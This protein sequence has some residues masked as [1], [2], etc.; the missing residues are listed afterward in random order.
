MHYRPPER[1]ERRIVPRQ[2][3]TTLEADD[4]IVRTG[5]ERGLAVRTGHAP[6]PESARGW[7]HK[8]GHDGYIKLV[9]D[10][11]RGV[12]AGATS[13]GRQAAR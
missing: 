6:V 3:E 13:A 12:L 11:G 10:T 7:I 8:A 1:S 5:R 4:G 9:E 2:P